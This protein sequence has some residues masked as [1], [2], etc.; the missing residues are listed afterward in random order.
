M[1]HFPSYSMKLVFCCYLKQKKTPL[2]KTTPPP[3]L[4][5]SK[6]NPTNFSKLYSKM[7]DWCQIKSI[8]G[9]LTG[10][11]AEVRRAAHI[12]QTQYWVKN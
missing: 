10:E 11:M 5:A 12:A 7:Q 8:L 2:N 4:K 9:L 6:L 3:P 1:E